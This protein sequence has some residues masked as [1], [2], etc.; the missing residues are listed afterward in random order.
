MA[1]Y[2]DAEVIKHVPAGLYRG[3][4]EKAD[5]LR[6][7]LSDLHLR[8]KTARAAGLATTFQDLLNSEWLALEFEAI[9]ARRER[10]NAKKGRPA[11]YEDYA[12]G[13][14]DSSDDDDSDNYGSDDGLTP[15]G[16]KPAGGEPSE[17]EPAGGESAGGQPA[18]GEPGAAKDAYLF[19]DLCDEPSKVADLVR[20]IQLY[21]AREDAERREL[22]APRRLEGAGAVP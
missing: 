9:N 10:Y 4:D 11:D 19:E 15:V 18:G 8:Q 13:R 21:E 17:G 1:Y 3:R 12:D 16:A 22:Y 14:F 2:S 20:L 6:R 7:R 5:L